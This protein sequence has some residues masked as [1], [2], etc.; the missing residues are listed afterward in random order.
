MKGTVG[1]PI[2]WV[3]WISLSW[4][5]L[6]CPTEV[7]AWAEGMTSQLPRFVNLVLTR[8]NAQ[9]RLILVSPPQVEPL[10]P[11]PLDLAVDPSQPLGYGIYFS[12]L[13]RQL[14]GVDSP[15]TWDNRRTDSLSLAYR[16]EV[17]QASPT[18]SLVLS[19]LQ[20]LRPEGIPRD[21]SDGA[22]AQGIRAW[23]AAGCPTAEDLQLTR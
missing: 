22:T 3:A 19:R 6:A 8:T 18:S 11:S 9:F 21:I 13:E 10:L 15:D 7:N 2:L 12:T 17:F 23:Q 20:V 16:A 1:I 4:P 5:A 14:V